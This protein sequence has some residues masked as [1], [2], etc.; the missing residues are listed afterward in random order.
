VQRYI[1]FE[2]AKKGFWRG[3]IALKEG[4]KR[5]KIAKPIKNGMAIPLFGYRN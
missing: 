3:K 5:K 1:I 2:K 4:Y